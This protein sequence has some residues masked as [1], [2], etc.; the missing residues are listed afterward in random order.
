MRVL[1]LS[2]LAC[3]C[4]LVA[5]CA[6]MPDYR[7]RPPAHRPG[8]PPHAAPPAQANRAM[9]ADQHYRKA[10]RFAA[11]GKWAA[12]EAQYRAALK[13]DPGHYRANAGLA[14]TLHELGHFVEAI[15]ILNEV[16]DH[17]P[18]YADAHYWLA[19]ALYATGEFVVAWEHIHD[20]E[21]LG[22][23]APS[24]F[25]QKLNAKHPEP[26]KRG[27]KGA[28]PP[29]GRG[30]GQNKGKGKNRESRWPW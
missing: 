30:G 26:G 7:A 15:H 9:N 20:Y 24:K 29:Q 28:G 2:L 23:R 11:Q 4:G 17:D 16:L 13:K 22:K 25:K 8:P 18:D 21:S 10:E 1:R 6:S 19:E 5:A 12:A 3:L 14:H 27:R